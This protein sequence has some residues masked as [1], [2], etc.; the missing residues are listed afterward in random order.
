[1]LV[2][3]IA[4]PSSPIST[5]YAAAKGCYSKDSS[6]EL[7]YEADGNRDIVCK[8]IKSI[9]DSGHESVLEHASFTFSIEGISRACS[10]QLVRHRIASYSQQSQRYVKFD[11][12]NEDAFVI[13]PEISKDSSLRELFIYQCQKS[14]MEYHTLVQTLISKGRTNEEACEDARYIIPNACKTNITMTMN[15]REIRHFIN[16]RSC[17]R[18]QWEIRELANRIHYL[19]DVFTDST[20]LYKCGPPCKFGACPEGSKSC[21]HPYK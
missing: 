18:A 12:T 15:L 10:H 5:I 7:L 21:G 6:Y 17:N 19:L 8:F 4:Q 11:I 14:M 9:I 1:M 16:Q 3:L 20:L 13:P 2:Q